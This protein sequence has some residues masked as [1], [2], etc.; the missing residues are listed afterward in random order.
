MRERAGNSEPLLL[1]TGQFCAEAI[2]PV[3][4]FVPQGCLLQASFDNF[5]QFRFFAQSGGARC[6]GDVVV[7]RQR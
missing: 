3:L 4:H 5:V 7:D 1:S 2:E 6:E